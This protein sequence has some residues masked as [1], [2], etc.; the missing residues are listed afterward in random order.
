MAHLAYVDAK[1]AEQADAALRR[2]DFPAEVGEHFSSH[3]KV[4]LAATLG[5][6]EEVRAVALRGVTTGLLCKRQDDIGPHGRPLGVDQL[7]AL[8]KDVDAEAVRCGRRGDLAPRL[9]RACTLWAASRPHW[10]VVVAV[11]ASLANR[12]ASAEDDTDGVAAAVWRAREGVDWL[13]AL[14]AGARSRSR[15]PLRRGGDCGGARCA[16]CGR[17][18]FDGDELERRADEA[19]RLAELAAVAPG[20]W[21]V[22]HVARELA[23]AVEALARLWPRRV[24]LGALGAKGDPWREMEALLKRGRADA[25]EASA[26]LLRMLVEALRASARD[27]PER[28][29]ALLKASEAYATRAAATRGRRE[30]PSS[31]SSSSSSSS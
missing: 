23:P 3:L 10:H 17:R 18:P 29:L 2:D 21:D 15:S 12:G 20:C 13:G 27:G 6:L 24:S 11:F 28:A 22:E 31:S 26:L 9:E 19:L 8:L 5:S 16:A 1:L 30:A 7:V 4:F 25:R 14:S